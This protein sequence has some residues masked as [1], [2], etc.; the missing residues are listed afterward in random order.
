MLRPLRNYLLNLHINSLCWGQIMAKQCGYQVA[1][2]AFLEE[3]VDF[4]A[5][6]WAFKEN[7]EQTLIDKNISS[8]IL[9]DYGGY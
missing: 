1:G 9:L 2:I 7:I 8:E 5:I 3:K 4:F 6:T